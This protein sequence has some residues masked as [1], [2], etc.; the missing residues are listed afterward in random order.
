MTMRRRCCDDAGGGVGGGG[1]VG[2]ES[3]E[4]DEEEGTA[5][6]EAGMLACG[7]APCIPGIPPS[8][9]P[10]MAVCC[11][12]CAESNL[13]SPCS[14]LLAILTMS[15]VTSSTSPSVT[16]L[17]SMETMRR[18]SSSSRGSLVMVMEVCLSLE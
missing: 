16:L 10:G 14:F 13:I 15:F 9:S 6:I 18:P 2:E 4:D 11:V 3:T 8:M 17:S 1:V 7:M 5:G 12:S